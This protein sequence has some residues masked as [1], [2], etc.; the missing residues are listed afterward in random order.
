M[1]S[2]VFGTLF[3]KAFTALLALLSS[4][5]KEYVMQVNFN[6]LYLRRETIYSSAL[7]SNRT[8]KSKFKHTENA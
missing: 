5:C 7:Q 4:I 8:P 1:E 2:S 6:L 3:R